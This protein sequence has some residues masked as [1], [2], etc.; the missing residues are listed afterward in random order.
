MVKAK[1][2]LDD[3]VILH[4]E[5]VHDYEL[6]HTLG[7]RTAIV[8]NARELGIVEIDVDLDEGTEPGLGATHACQVR[9]AASAAC[10]ISRRRTPSVR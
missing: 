8:A 1:G 2:T 5:V 6:V 10:N 3:L 7:R 4:Q 9:A